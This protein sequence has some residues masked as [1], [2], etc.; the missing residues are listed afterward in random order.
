MQY[1][2]HTLAIRSPFAPQML[3]IDVRTNVQL[4]YSK[5]RYW[6]HH[7][8]LIFLFTQTLCVFQMNPV[9]MRLFSAGVFEFHL[10]GM[11]FS[12]NNHAV[13]L[14]FWL[15]C[16]ISK[17]FLSPLSPTAILGFICLLGTA[18]S[19]YHHSIV[20]VCSCS[21]SCPCS[22]QPTPPTILLTVDRFASFRMRHEFTRIN[23]A[24]WRL[25]I[26]MCVGAECIDKINRNTFLLL[27]ICWP[28]FLSGLM[29]NTYKLYLL[30]TSIYRWKLL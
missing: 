10:F 6:H 11:V 25:L 30:E 15:A 12:C 1:A 18:L 16:D 27:F 5:R 20:S 23:V 21:Y 24:N 9:W 2:R 3:P 29:W 26:T 14:H 22:I 7:W 19:V 8:H 17:V 13:H 28:I 4:Q